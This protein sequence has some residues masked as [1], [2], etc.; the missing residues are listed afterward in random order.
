M[1]YVVVVK[2]TSCT[3]Q[4]TSRVEVVKTKD[5]QVDHSGLARCVSVTS[6]SLGSFNSCV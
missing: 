6:V 5:K 4:V 1:L 2:Y 3:L